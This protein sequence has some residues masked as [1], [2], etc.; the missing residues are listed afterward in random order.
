MGAWRNLPT[1]GKWAVGIVAAVVLIAV[2]GGGGKKKHHG[3]ASSAPAT[4]Q[5]ASCVFQATENCTP[6]VALSQPVRVDAIIYN[7]VSVRTTAA[8]GDPSLLGARA[9][10][11]FIVVTL[12]AHSVKDT[13]DTLT[14]ATIKLTVPNGP[15]YSASTDASTALLGN[16]STGQQ[17][18][19][20]RQINPD[21][22][23]QGQ[24]A[25]DVPQ[26]VIGEH[27]ELRFNEL[28]L[29]STHAYIRLPGL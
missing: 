20:L 3:A 12:N 10:G 9:T 23:I 8:I 14:D 4:T 24:I 6:H 5:S 25:F 1:G 28:G 17:P 2:A 19:F 21:E 11:T 18:F 16:S 22:T 27:P 7:V 26:A 15:E 29:G 13:S